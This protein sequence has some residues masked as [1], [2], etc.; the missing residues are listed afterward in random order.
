MMILTM[1]FVRLEL[2]LRNTI[3]RLSWQ[4]ECGER[5]T[6]KSALKVRTEAQGALVLP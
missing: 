5:R 6:R 3:S 1:N 4:C 2:N